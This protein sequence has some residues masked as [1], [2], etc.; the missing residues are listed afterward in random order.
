MAENLNINV[1]DGCWCYN[2]NNRTVK[3]DRLYTWEAAKRD[4]EWKQL[5]I[6]LV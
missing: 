5:E 3:Y 6:Y 4:A 2:K 1:G